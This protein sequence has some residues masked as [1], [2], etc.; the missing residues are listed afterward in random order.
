VRWYLA[1]SVRDCRIFGGKQ[2]GHYWHFQTNRY[3]REMSSY[4]VIQDRIEKLSG[5]GGA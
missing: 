4:N 2:I 3:Q 5:F 1:Y